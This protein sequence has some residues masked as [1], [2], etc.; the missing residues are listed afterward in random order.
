LIETV[1]APVG[2]DRRIVGG[3]LTPQEIGLV[4]AGLAAL[5]CGLRRCRIRNRQKAD[6]VLV[7][8]QRELPGERLGVKPGRRVV[9]PV[10][11]RLRYAVAGQ[12]VE[13]DILECPAQFARGSSAGLAISGEMAG[14]IDQRNG[15]GDHRSRSPIS[16]SALRRLRHFCLA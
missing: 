4:L 6:I 5:R 11:Q 13:P 14:D 3:A 1:K 7:H 2:D 15:A 10:D 8:F 12:V 9:G 16:H